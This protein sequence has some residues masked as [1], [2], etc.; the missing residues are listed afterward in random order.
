MILLTIDDLKQQCRILSDDENSLL[1]IYGLAAEDWV[2]QY[3]GRPVVAEEPAGI[4]AATL[5]MAATLYAFRES[6]ITAQ[7]YEVR[8]CKAML[9]PHR[10]G[11]IL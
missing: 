3:L 2:S 1:E 10:V 4:K 7:T 5:M 9:D 6:E 11:D 8:A